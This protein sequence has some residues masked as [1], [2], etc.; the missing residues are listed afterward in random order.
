MP[1]TPPLSEFDT[2][3]PLASPKPHLPTS[4]TPLESSPGSNEVRAVFQ[5]RASSIRPLNDPGRIPP[6][7]FNVEPMHA[8]TLL[9]DCGVNGPPVSTV[10]ST[11]APIKRR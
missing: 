7:V 4:P 11:V 6:A 3:V 5:I 2:D 8:L 9:A 1:F 10:D